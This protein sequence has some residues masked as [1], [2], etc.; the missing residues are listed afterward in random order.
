MR[1]TVLS[2]LMIAITALWT[3]SV[4]I[5]SSEEYAEAR[6]VTV[7]RGN[8]HQVVAV[9]GRLAYAD[10][11]YA[12]A[13]MNGVVSQVCVTAG[14]R[15]AEDE[16]LVRFASDMQEDALSAVAANSTAIEGAMSNE[17]IAEQLSLSNTV[18]R[19]EQACTV[20]QVLV[21]ENMPVAAG[22]P[23]LRITSNQQH[24]VCSVAPTDA[25]RI[26]SDMWAWLY[27]EGKP[28][29]FAEV[30]SIGELKSDALTGSTSAELILS[31]ERPLELPEGASVDAEI[32]IAGS[33]EVMTLPI[34]AITDRGTVWWIGDDGKCTEIPAKIVMTDE[35]NAWVHLPEGIHVA[36]GE[37][38]E[39]QRIREADK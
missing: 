7:Q 15:V 36:V 10:E 27:A 12:Y 5:P 31:P 16:A 2:L 17:W 38:E 18:V 35:I 22:T 28:T 1:K 21:T 11:R 33:D 8:V 4:L 3:G 34:E 29:G 37:F 26:T 39:G 32:Y 9:T 14:Q 23:I 30:V 25:G 13:Q 19:A 6:I 20:R 24:I